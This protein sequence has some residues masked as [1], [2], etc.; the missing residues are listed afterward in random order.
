M[1][2]AQLFRS[3]RAAA[4]ALGFAALTVFA[5]L[6]IGDSRPAGAATARVRCPLDA[7]A[8]ASPRQVQ[9][10]FSQ[11]GPPVG[12]HPGLKSTYTHGH[13]TWLNG[14]ATGWVCHQD[15]GGGK[16]KRHVVLRVTKG[17]SE[18]HGRVM[19]LGHIGVEIVLPLQVTATDDDTCAVGTRA[20]VTL[21]ASYYDVHIDKGVL[22]FQSG[23]KTH[24][25]TW[26][27]P[28]LKVLVTR[29]GAQV[30]GP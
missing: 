7:K 1:A 26:R 27:E 19:R 5:A 20:K 3:H 25:H 8:A 30:D 28:D 29:K 10:A 14:H 17:K 6:L 21:Y 13:G 9:W 22:H 15:M 18:I 2:L 11:F 23:C 16:P 4:L 24:D 12:K